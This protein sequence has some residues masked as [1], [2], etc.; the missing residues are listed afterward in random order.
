MDV[1]TQPNCAVTSF[2]TF[3]LAPMSLLCA[4]FY[5]SNPYV[6]PLY[7][8]RPPL[9]LSPPE[10]I[11]LLYLSHSTLTKFS[12]RAFPLLSFHRYI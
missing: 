10:S 12:R 8:L 7:C 2:P 6:G 5:H 1:S 9:H 4:A 11:A 3:S